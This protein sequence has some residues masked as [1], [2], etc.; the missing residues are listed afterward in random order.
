MSDIDV[1]ADALARGDDPGAAAAL[2]ASLGWPRGR[3]VTGELAPYFGVIAELAER[4]GADALAQLAQLAQADPDS[5][6]RLYDLGYALIDA[7]APA[8]AASVLWRCLAL[9]GDSEEV[10]C[11]LVSALET[12]LEYRDAFAVLDGLSDLRERSFLCRYLHA[13]D[14]AMIGRLDVTRSALPDLAPDSPETTAMT[15]TIAGIVARADRAAAACALDDRD[16]RGWHYVLTGGVLTHVS[17]YGFDEPMRGRYA[18]LADSLARVSTGLDRLCTL[19]ERYDVPCVYAPP[20]RDH[21]IVARAAAARLGLPLAEWPAVGV[22]APGLVV[23]YDLADLPASEVARLVERRDRQILF[24][25]ASPWTHDA[26]VAPDVTTLL[27]ETLV[28]PWGEAVV[29]DPDARETRRAPADARPAEA[30]AE[31]LAA[32]PGL[33][34]DELASDDS[35]QLSALVACA[36]PPAPGPRSRLWAGGPVVSNRFE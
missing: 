1:I 28:A 33:D 19:V 4:R 15:H 27:Y 17:P 35:G 34:A 8:I 18:W 36:W 7:G 30:I 21:D 26:P 24:A 9:V 32:A 25:H 3:D 22:P 13:F 12:A 29:V 14:A 16:L 31:E 10:V 20:G 11:E 5:P 6:D 23:L 2:R